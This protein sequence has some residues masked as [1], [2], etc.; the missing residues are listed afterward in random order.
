MPT[1]QVICSSEF[2][3]RLRLFAANREVTMSEVVLSAVEEYIEKEDQASD[4]KAT[5]TAKT[6]K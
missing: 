5:K 1:L 3:K 6:K 4:T 2:K